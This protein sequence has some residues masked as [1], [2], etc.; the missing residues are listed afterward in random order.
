M[1]NH[2]YC[3]DFL[4]MPP[5]SHSRPQSYLSSPAKAMLPFLC[6]LELLSVAPKRAWSGNFAWLPSITSH[7][8]FP[9]TWNQQMKRS[10]RPS[11]KIQ[12]DLLISK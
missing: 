1:E 2:I 4:H 10:V 11:G 3:T 9:L 12:R 8:N 5:P 7:E 6:T